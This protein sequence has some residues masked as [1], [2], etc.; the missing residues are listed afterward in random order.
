ME[1]GF[2][3]ETGFVET[4]SRFF[5][6]ELAACFKAIYKTSV[7]HLSTSIPP[8]APNLETMPSQFYLYGKESSSSKEVDLSEAKDAK[9]IRQ[10]VGA[11]FSIAVSSTISFHRS[12]EKN[13]LPSDLSSLSDDELLKLGDEKVAL[14]ISGKQV[15]DVPGP[16]G[17]L[18]F[19][20]GYS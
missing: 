4:A 18:P 8:S 15:R 1:N 13:T 20:G 11:E 7:S 10:V 16:S 14:L 17:G 3:T 6:V 5:E 19:I 2:D 12:P 9:S